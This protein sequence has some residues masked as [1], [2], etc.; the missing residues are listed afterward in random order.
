MGT[1]KLLKIINQVVNLDQIITNN[2]ILEHILD[3]DKYTNGLNRYISKPKECNVIGDRVES[4]LNPIGF[5]IKLAK[6][7]K[8]AESI[9]KQDIIDARSILCFKFVANPMSCLSKLKILWCLTKQF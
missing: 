9:I 3:K 2:E 4:C 1:Q 7:P 8:Y 5:A 6:G